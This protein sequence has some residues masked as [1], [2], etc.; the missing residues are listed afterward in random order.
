MY[1]VAVERGVIYGRASRDP[2][3]GGTSVSKQ[4]ERGRNFAQRDGVDVVAEIR[5]DNKSASRGSRERDGFL[6]VRGLIDAGRA[7]VLILW[8]VSRSSRDLE[9]FMGLVNACAD[10]GLEIAVSGTRY[11]PTKV[12]DWLPLV[13]QGVMA[14]AEARRIKKRNIDS[15]ETNALRG[16]PHGR[17]PYGFR[18]CYDS[19]TGILVGQTPF[20]RVDSSGSPVRTPEG[21]FVPVLSDEAPR[22]LSPEAVVLVEAV[23][24]LLDGGTLR[25]ICRD[26]NTRGIPTPRKA[27]RSTLEENPMGVVTNWEPSTLRQLLLNPTIA[28]RRI[29]RGEDIG[30]ASWE[31]IVPHGTW[32]RLRALLKDPARLSVSN[33]RG[34]APRHLLSG[35]ATCGECHARLKAATN[36]S[37]M[38]RAYACRNEGCMRVTVSADRVDECVEAVLFALFARPDFIAS[39][40]AAHDRREKKRRD[41]P[42]LESLIDERERELDEVEGMRAE[43]SLTLRAY[44][45]ETRRIEASIE[46]LRDSQTASVSSPAVR[47]MLTALTLEEGWTR[48]DLQDR[49]E[50]VRTLLGVTIKRAE[51]RGRKF[52]PDRVVIVPSRILAFD[53]LQPSSA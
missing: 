25:Q 23:N 35:I 38:P 50:V 41:E 6:K 3:G 22:T 46:K 43:G 52:D 8:E 4:I 32:L 19:R 29:H 21:E 18:R 11:N 42:D 39:V 14:E 51:V 53:S 5:D 37:R 2:R 17:I 49:R 45:A 20:V 30:K 27:R 9:E 10:N 26:L 31:P 40:A 47:R 24:T 13:L 36:L 33:P 48:A 12:D 16:S 7:D 15:V 44:A 28:G 1:S 34:P